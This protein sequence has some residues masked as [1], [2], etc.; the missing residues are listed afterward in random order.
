MNIVPIIA[1][2]DDGS[3][4]LIFFIVV[5]VIIGISK[6]I[7]K[8]QESSS[9]PAERPP[10][11]RPQSRPTWQ[12]NSDEVRK[13]LEQLSGKPDQTAPPP[14]AVPPPIT[15]KRAQ[16]YRGRAVQQ[17]PPAV[18]AAPAPSTYKRHL[19]MDEGE[20]TVAADSRDLLQ[21]AE[22]ATHVER[23]RE[24][25]ESTRTIAEASTHAPSAVG[26]GAAGADE[27]VTQSISTPVLAAAPLES[28][29]QKTARSAPSAILG[30]Y[31]RDRD[32]ARSAYILAEIL[33]TPKGA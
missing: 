17:K 2:E 11:P 18:P 27:M 31:L 24:I 13:F 26:A 3:F 28:A 30:Q 1:A 8:L 22:V 33:G 10:Q 4:K 32:N 14:V 19:E 12:A 23:A 5:M 16:Q 29:R 15:I 9:K 21:T 20:D 6:L 25:E 7:K